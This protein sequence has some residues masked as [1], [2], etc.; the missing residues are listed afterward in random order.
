[1]FPNCYM[2]RAKWHTGN[3]V[4]WEMDVPETTSISIS[5]FL[6]TSIFTVFAC[7]WLNNSVSILYQ[8]FIGRLFHQGQSLTRKNTG[9]RNR[10]KSYLL[11]KMFLS[12]SLRWRISK[13]ATNKLR[14]NVNVLQSL[15]LRDTIEQKKVPM[16]SFKTNHLKANTNNKQDKFQ[17]FLN[18][19]ATSAHDTSG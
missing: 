1:M 15:L 13:P 16:E 9:L 5:F 10:N 2:T 14:Q 3:R 17:S 11:V 12:R 4:W 7:C 19:N 8:P 18:P 6:P